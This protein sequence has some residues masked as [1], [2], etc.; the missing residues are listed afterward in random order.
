VIDSPPILLVSDAKVLARVTEATVVIFNAATTRRGAAL[1]TLDEVG[2]VKGNVVGCVL[3]GVKAI[4][5]GYYRRQY[6]SYRRYLKPQLA[7]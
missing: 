7:S 1:R 3:F 5:G 2:N 6:R 4:K